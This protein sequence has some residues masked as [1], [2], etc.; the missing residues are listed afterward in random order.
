MKK[1]EL[2][3]PIGE[4]N[5]AYDKYF[6]GKSYLCPLTDRNKTFLL[7]NVAFEPGCR[8]NWHIHH[9]KKGGGQI[10]IVVDGEGY[11]Q[12]EG[13]DPISLTKGMVVTIEANIKH[14]H[15]AK[16]NSWFQHIA[17][18]VE[19]LDKSTEW[20]EKVDDDYYNSLD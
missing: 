19:G 8:N 3:F 12:E 7:T 20:C 17:I 9:A 2:S 1:E 10:L 15:G 18:D 4:E 6:V 13:K 16:K 5:I 14:W 11:Y